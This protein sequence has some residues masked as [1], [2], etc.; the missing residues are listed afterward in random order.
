MREASKA[1]ELSWYFGK[2]SS[3]SKQVLKGKQSLGKGA[4]KADIVLDRED[5][6]NS[7]L[8]RGRHLEVKGNSF[9][10]AS[11]SLCEVRLK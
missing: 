3:S 2:M 5:I 10:V 7:Q 4:Y 6:L 8:M 9:Y 11:V 1:A